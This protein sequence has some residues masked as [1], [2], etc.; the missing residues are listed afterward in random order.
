MKDKISEISG[1][2]LIAP[3]M[4]VLTIWVVFWVEVRFNYNFNHWGIQP[5]SISGLKGVLFSP[6]IHS[7]VE[8]LYNNTIPLAVLTFFL[9]LFYRRVALRV[10]LMGV[11]GAGILTWVIGRPS[12]H[13]GASG[14]IYVLASFIFFK[15]IITKHYRWVALSL[16]VVFVYGSMIWYIF[17][18]KDGISWEGHL[19]GFLMGLLL[20]L[21]VRIDVLKEKKYD[22]EKEDFDEESDPFLQHFDAE[23]NFI[24]SSENEEEV[25]VPVKV[26]YHFKPK[27]DED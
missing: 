9:F 23:G 27:E 7:S 16:I 6:F 22:W 15:G 8:H 3:L 21:L 20:A 18:V 14:L 13:I 10:V 19:S 25:E 2:V 24:G 1:K 12:Y 26:K 4:A 5:R 17:P 11:L